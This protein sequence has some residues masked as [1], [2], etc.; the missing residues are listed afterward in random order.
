MKTD[1]ET[2]RCMSFDIWNTLII[3]D[4]QF[5]Q[6][7]VAIFAKS[8]G[9]VDLS[10][11]AVVAKQIDDDYDRRSE[12]TGEDFDFTARVKG[13]I[14]AVHMDPALFDE[15]FCL[16]LQQE[17]ND[18]FIAMI[19]S[20][21]EKDLKTTLGAL[22][23]KGIKL[24]LLSNTGFIDGKTMRVA[25]ERLGILHFFDF[26]V[27]SNEVQIAK[28]HKQIYQL[29]VAQSGFK[30]EEIMHIGDNMDADYKGARSCGL[31]ALLY[32]RKGSHAGD[33]ETIKSLEELL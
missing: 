17:V 10:V 2:V 13:I 21:I 31:H 3:G 7:R 12:L 11:M 32:D 33:A 18:A 29:L 28:P 30:S 26:A 15:A 8:L 20:F 5:K 23:D 22:K 9:D 1:L 19:P 25:L 6:A 4:P 27:F 24:A 16:D 14:G